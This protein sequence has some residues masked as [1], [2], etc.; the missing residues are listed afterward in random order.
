MSFDENPHTIKE[1]LKQKPFHIHNFEDADDLLYYCFTDRYVI[2]DSIILKNYF[3][4][5]TNRNVIN[6][7]SSYDKFTEEMEKYFDERTIF[8]NINFCNDVDI[9][10]IINK[11]NN[12]MID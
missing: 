6:C 7:N 1:Q 2:F 8:N 4:N 3:I 5:N 10:N 9:L 11:T 12:L